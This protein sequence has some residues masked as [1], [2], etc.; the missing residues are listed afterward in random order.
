MR[1]DNWKFVF[2]EM[3]KPGGFAVW[4]DPFTCL[5]VPKIFNLRMDPYERADVV[6]DQYNDWVT[7][8]AYLTA[9]GVMKSAAFLETFIEYPPSQKPASFSVDQIEEGVHAKINEILA[10][11][12]PAQ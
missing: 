8:N 3:R 1:F 4:Q 12:P 11:T 9:Q 10:K 2:C 6:S 7:K 5:R